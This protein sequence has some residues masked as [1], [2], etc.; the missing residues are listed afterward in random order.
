M[1][2]KDVQ[3]TITDTSEWTDN[4]RQWQ[5]DGCGEWF[6]DAD[7]SEHPT[8]KGD[9]VLTCRECGKDLTKAFDRF[10]ARIHAELER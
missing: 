4:V 7:L 3:I 9:I 2:D 6:W 8:A 10:Y 1:A 5:C